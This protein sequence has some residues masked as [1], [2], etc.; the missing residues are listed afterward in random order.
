VCAAFGTDGAP[1]L[2][3][4]GEGTSFRLGDVVLKRVIDDAE[5]EW[6]Q[7]LLTRVP[8]DGYRSAEP[9]PTIDDRWVHDGWIAHRYIPDLRPAAPN[10]DLVMRAGVRFGDAAEEVRGD[11][12]VLTRRT[13]RWAVADRVAWGEAGVEMGAAAT[14]L[15]S[16]VEARLVN[17]VDTVQFVHGDLSGNVFLDR[18]GT[19]VV[20]DVS[21]YIRPRE[22]AAAIVAV[23]A[24]LWSAANPRLLS[25]FAHTDGRRDLV[26]RAFAFRLVADELSDGPWSGEP[27]ARHRAVFPHLP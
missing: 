13:H 21:P 18:S 11:P 15:L 22:W 2:L 4:G 23:D 8:Q 14:Q 9:V 24:V 16:D 19:P 12:E 20:L 1:Q 17:A 27:L 10:W 3:D 26:L 7:Q 25:E 6:T 5:S